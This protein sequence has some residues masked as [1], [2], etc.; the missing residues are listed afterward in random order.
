[1][2]P[3][4]GFKG[5]TMKRFQNASPRAG[6]SSGAGFLCLAGALLMT[7]AG[8]AF[9]SGCTPMLSKKT[10][11]AVGKTYKARVDMRINGFRRTYRVYVPPGYRA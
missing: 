6:Q 3:Q 10:E 7:V 9:F 4:Q 1:L 5:Y 2:C 8:S 11:P